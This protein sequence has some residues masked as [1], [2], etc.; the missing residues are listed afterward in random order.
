MITVRSK[1]THCDHLQ[2]KQIWIKGAMKRYFTSF[3]LLPDGRERHEY[4]YNSQSLFMFILWISWVLEWEDCNIQI[5]ALTI[6]LLICKTQ[7][8]FQ[9]KLD[10]RKGIHERDIIESLTFVSV[11]HTGSYMTLWINNS[12]RAHKYSIQ[13]T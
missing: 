12:W 2:V 4:M 13:S 7:V 6:H 8:T 1:W 5:E 3:F 11:C 9:I 10:R